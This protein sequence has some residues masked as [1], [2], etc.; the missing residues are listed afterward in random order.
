VNKITDVKD[1]PPP[2]LEEEVKTKP[3]ENLSI[4]AIAA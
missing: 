4:T 2:L 1:D 3:V